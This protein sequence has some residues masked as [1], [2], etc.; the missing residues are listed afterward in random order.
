MECRRNANKKARV[1]MME[2]MTN[3]EDSSD[4]II[5]RVTSSEYFPSEL[6]STN[7]CVNT[8][9]RMDLDGRDEYAINDS[10]TDNLSSD[11]SPDN[12]SADDR[13]KSDDPNVSLADELFFFTFCFISQIG[14]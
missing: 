2:M 6:P 1:A 4:K 13:D 3:E 9:E 14:Q 11:D 12:D 8:H 5:H 7:C 10:S